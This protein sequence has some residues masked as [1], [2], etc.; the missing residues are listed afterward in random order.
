MWEQGAAR[1]SLITSWLANRSC[2]CPRPAKQLLVLHAL[3]RHLT[4]A[5]HNSKPL[6]C[7][8]ALQDEEAVQLRIKLAQKL[9]VLSCSRCSLAALPAQFAADDEAMAGVQVSRQ[10]PPAQVLK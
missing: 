2:C 3:M 4:H 6:S 7:H 10:Q 5:L 1:A 9:G 8:V